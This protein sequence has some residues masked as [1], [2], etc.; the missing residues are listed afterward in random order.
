MVAVGLWSWSSFCSGRA[1][2]NCD[3][4]GCYCSSDGGLSRS[5]NLCC[6]FRGCDSGRGLV[7]VVVV[8]AQVAVVVAVVVVVVVVVVWACGC[9]LGPP[10]RWLRLW[11]SLFLRFFVLS[12][13]RFFFS[14]FLSFFVS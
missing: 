11:V 1:C 12:F 14:S 3:Q 5:C 6:S 4:D 7:V 2:L 9:G 13:R 8:V 10:C